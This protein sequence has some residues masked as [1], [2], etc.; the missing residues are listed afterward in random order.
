MT[1]FT[2]CLIYR[3]LAGAQTHYGWSLVESHLHPRM[4]AR[5]CIGDGDEWIDPACIPASPNLWTWC[6]IILNSNGG[7]RKVAYLI[8]VN[9]LTW[10]QC[11]CCLKW[12]NPS[13]VNNPHTSSSLLH[14]WHVMTSC[15]SCRKPIWY[16][17]TWGALHEFS[18]CYLSSCELPSFRDL[19]RSWWSWRLNPQLPVLQ[20]PAKHRSCGVAMP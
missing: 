2:S 12:G 8:F 10:P 9:S 4:E 20:V 19:S 1:F 5:N 7:L 18:W 11:E 13:K 17:T 14:G 3:Q 6:L 15:E 16:G